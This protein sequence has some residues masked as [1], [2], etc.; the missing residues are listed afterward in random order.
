[1]HTCEELGVY[2]GRTPPCDAQCTQP[3]P[4]TDIDDPILHAEGC[5]RLCGAAFCIALAVL[6]AAAVL[7]IL[8][9]YDAQLRAALQWLREVPLNFF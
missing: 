6:V 5:Q 8:W 4:S 3:S 2:Q 7:P 1:M 9:R